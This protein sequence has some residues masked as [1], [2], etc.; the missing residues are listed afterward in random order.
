MSHLGAFGEYFGEGLM[1]IAWQ[2]GEE[3]TSHRG[4]RQRLGA[5]RF[6]AVEV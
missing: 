1:E 2:Q 5:G 6:D 4:K 3:M